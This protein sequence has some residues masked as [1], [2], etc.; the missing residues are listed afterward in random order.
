MKNLILFHS[1]YIFKSVNTLNTVKVGP[2][3]TS[4]KY[5][6]MSA[7]GP[8]IKHYNKLM[9]YTITKT[10]QTLFDFELFW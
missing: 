2:K 5:S 7:F 10:S 1:N 3:Q 4:W 8:S 6:D 9:F